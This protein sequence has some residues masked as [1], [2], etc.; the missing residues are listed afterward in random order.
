[1]P[2]LQILFTDDVTQ[3]HGED[4]SEEAAKRIEGMIDHPECFAQPNWIIVES[5]NTKTFVNLSKVLQFRIIR[6]EEC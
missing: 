4:I 1:M 5:G 2:R 3:A 6:E